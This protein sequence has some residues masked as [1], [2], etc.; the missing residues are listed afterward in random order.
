MAP[1]APARISRIRS[2][3]NPRLALAGGP[4]GLGF[5]RRIAADLPDY[6][7]VEGRLIVE[8]GE[9]QDDAVTDILRA[10]GCG[11]IARLR[12][13]SGLVRVLTARG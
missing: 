10:A 8:I 6:L 9:G 3:R 11:T 13:P 4:D 12:D 7:A 2:A 5:Y 1:S